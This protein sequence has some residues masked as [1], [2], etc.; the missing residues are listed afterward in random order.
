MIRSDNHRVY[1]LS[2]LITASFTASGEEPKVVCTEASGGSSTLI[3]SSI[4]ITP[5]LTSPIVITPKLI[6]PIVSDVSVVNSLLW[7]KPYPGQ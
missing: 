4:V 2:D 1:R 5:K 6:S 3:T 7:E